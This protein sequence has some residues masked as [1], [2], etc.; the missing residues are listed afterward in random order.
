MKLSE[1][2]FHCR[3]RAGLSQETLAEQLGVS[4]QAVSRWEC[5][6]T[7]PEPMKI[8]AIARAFGVSTDWLLDEEKGIAEPKNSE[9]ESAA[10]M[11]PTGKA[12]PIVLIPPPKRRGD[13]ALG[14]I[15][16][17]VGLG[18]LLFFGAVYLFVTRF[19]GIRAFNLLIFPFSLICFGGGIG[20]V[21]FGIVFLVRGIRKKA[22]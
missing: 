19:T 11:P 10:D 3:Q 18:C 9:T 5:G 6:E 8:L 12:E 1:K 17:C 21:A 14:I 15:L 7:M 4:R 20:A 22:Q 2:I 16:L 13:R